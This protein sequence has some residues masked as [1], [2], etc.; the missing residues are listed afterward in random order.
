MRNARDDTM[1]MGI[2]DNYLCAICDDGGFLIRCDG[3]CGRLFHPNSSHG[4][5]SSCRG[6]ELKDDQLKSKSFNFICK[7]CEY[8][9]HQCFVCG[10]LG[11]SEMPP[12]SPEEVLKCQKKYCG[13][14]Y[15]PKCLSKYD[16]TKNRQDFECPLHECHSCK[17]KGETVITSEQ[18][19]KK[20]ET[21]L[22]QCRRCPVAYHRKCLPRDISN[23]ADGEVARTFKIGM[24][25]GPRRAP[26][27]KR[28]PRRWFFYCRKH[29]MVGELNSATR[30]H[31]KIPESP[32]VFMSDL[33][34][35]LPEET[36]APEP[37]ASTSTAPMESSASRPSLPCQQPEG[38]GGWLDD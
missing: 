5:H 2:V 4:Q 23:V 15:H 3:E 28:G 16:P 6:L 1:K 14:F 7:N 37:N 32:V 29:E 22:V 21:Y 36:E 11:S 33:N 9:K 18:T 17:N 26:S 13:R 8:K 10:E 31:L 19:E 25:K 30:D 35:K 38:Y 12:G 24:P 27:K 34:E 20:K